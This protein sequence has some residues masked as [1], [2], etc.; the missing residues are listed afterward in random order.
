MMMKSAQCTAREY[1]IKCKALMW[2][3]GRCRWCEENCTRL[4][5]VVMAYLRGAEEE[6]EQRRLK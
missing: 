1:R 6:E 3:L 5:I 4:E 2:H